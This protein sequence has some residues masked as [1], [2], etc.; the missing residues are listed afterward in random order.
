MI[1]IPQTQDPADD[2][3][4]RKQGRASFR[5]VYQLLSSIL[6]PSAQHKQ[7]KEGRVSFG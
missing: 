5:N 1:P 3:V 7:L 2:M 4:K 6:V